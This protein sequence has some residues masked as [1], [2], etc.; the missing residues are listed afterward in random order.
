MGFGR[1]V[2]KF[3][4]L[5]RKVGGN[6]DRVSAVLTACARLH[7]FIIEWRGQ[8]DTHS[9]YATV[10]EEMEALQITPNSDA[11]LGMSFLPVVPDEE[12]EAFPGISRTREAIV[13]HIR[14]HDIRRPLH[15]IVRQRR[16]QLD[17]VVVSP[18]GHHTDCEFISPI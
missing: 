1:L 13:E 8:D 15:N 9:E 14:E 4:I 5:S 10:E 18:N 6:I 16:E 3:R 12:F 7:N 11:P 17:L 2:N